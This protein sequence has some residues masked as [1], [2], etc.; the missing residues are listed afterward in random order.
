MEYI[1][2]QEERFEMQEQFNKKLLERL[3]EQQKYIEER[4]NNRDEMLMQSIRETQETKQ[5]LLAAKE[6]EQK[7]PRKGLFKWFSN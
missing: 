4:L 1:E 3:D 6:E 5:L 7:K 2:R